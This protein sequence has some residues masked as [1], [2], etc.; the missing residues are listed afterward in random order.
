MSNTP[1]I[2]NH[3]II[4]GAGLSGLVLAYKLINSSSPAQNN[5]FKITLLER[6]ENESSRGQ[7]VVIG[8]RQ[9]GC[10]V[11]KNSQLD[12]VLINM[13]TNDKGAATDLALCSQTGRLLVYVPKLMTVNLSDGSTRSSLIDR[14]SLR[15]AMLE[16]LKTHP[17]STP[18]RLVLK[19]N[20]KVTGVSQPD[21]TTVVVT[22]HNGET[23]QGNLLVGA[24]GAR[25]VVRGICCPALIPEGLGIYNAAGVVENV[26]S[27]FKNKN[28]IFYNTAAKC[29]TRTS[30]SNGASL[31]LFVGPSDQLLWSFS[32]PASE[33]AKGL[34]G[35]T[36]NNNAI[37][38]LPDKELISLVCEMLGE[39][40]SNSKPLIDII[41]STSKIVPGYEMFS[42]RNLELFKTT[43]C[44]KNGY[45]R[46]TLMGDAL[47]KTTTQAGVGATAAFLDA[48]D[49]ANAL[50]ASPSPN[51][52]EQVV[53]GYEKRSAARA[54]DYTWQSLSNTIRLHQK[55][56][57]MS[58]TMIN[59][60]MWSVG[61]IISGIIGIRNGWKWVKSFVV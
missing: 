5:N 48:E 13:L 39:S 42:V 12:S 37:P 44:S 38:P 47:H 33:K 6:D 16:K 60:I 11:L 17:N 55:R 24:D 9:E 46:V 29:L 57:M 45:N 32:C 14:A 26:S 27:I 8:L 51:D 4:A 52:I 61:C 43:T 41:G 30:G 31:L 53:L 35:H 1:P 10:D 7:G 18:E 34:I 15:Q 49:L 59:S 23:I 40:F 58:E 22:L 36:N 21:K 25:S 3:I 20:S 50:I 19:F 54:K 56:G 2:T 28:N